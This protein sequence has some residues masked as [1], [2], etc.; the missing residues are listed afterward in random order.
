MATY[1]LGAEACSSTS[2]G[3]ARRAAPLGKPSGA[4]GRVTFFFPSYRRC[5]VVARASDVAV[6][7]MAGLAGLVDT[8]QRA[9]E[10]GVPTAY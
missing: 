8:R 6:P 4:R 1:E 9:A 5:P 10:P 2:A 3:R 7:G